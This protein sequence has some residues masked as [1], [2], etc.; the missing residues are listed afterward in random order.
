MMIRVHIMNNRKRYSD[1]SYMS[2]FGAFLIYLVYAILCNNHNNISLKEVHLNDLSWLRQPQLSWPN[3]N[4]KSSVHLRLRLISHASPNCSSI[5]HN[6]QI[7]N[8]YYNLQHNYV[9][10]GMNNISS[11]RRI[12]NF[13]GAKTL[14][15]KAPQIYEGLTI[16]FIPIINKIYHIK[17]C[18]RHDLIQM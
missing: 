18:T 1:K 13:V 16:Q 12:K 4:F 10:L 2:Q 9:L 11:W 6:V 14:R 7:S 5:R 15:D 17:N 8:C 3:R